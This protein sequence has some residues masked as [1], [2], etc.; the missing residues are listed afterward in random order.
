MRSAKRRQLTP[1]SAVPPLQACVQSY[2]LYEQ[3][4]L[5]ACVP[6]ALKGLATEYWTVTSR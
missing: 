1:S 4:L 3:A 2:G 5:L 6:S